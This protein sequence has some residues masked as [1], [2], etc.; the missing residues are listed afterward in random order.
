MT[1]FR[2]SV[3]FSGEKEVGQAVYSNLKEMV[4]E[5]RRRPVEGLHNVR[6]LFTKLSEVPLRE[7]EN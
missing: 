1:R 3:E 5:L 7:W 6:V 4:N 2:L